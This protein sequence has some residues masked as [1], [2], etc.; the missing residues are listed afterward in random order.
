[1]GGHRRQASSRFPAARRMHAHASCQ[2]SDLPRHSACCASVVGSHVAAAPTTRGSA[3]R[4]RRLRT[5]TDP[6]TDTT[7]PTTTPTTAT[8]HHPHDDDHPPSTTTT[9]TVR[10]RP[11]D[12][13]AR[14]SHHD[15]AG[16]PRRRALGPDAADAIAGH[17]G[18]ETSSIPAL[19]LHVVEVPAAQVDA[20]QSRVPRRRARA[21]AR[22]STRSATPRAAR[23]I[24]P[25]ATSGRFPRSAGKTSTVSSTPRAPR[26]SRCSTPVSTR[27]HP[28]SPGGRSG[29]WSF[30]GSDPATDPNGHGTHVATIAAGG[31][32]DGTGIAGVAYAGVTVMPVRVLG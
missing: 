22:H 4:G 25:T 8:E 7:P 31:A 23:P 13:H 21:S 11:D 16:P 3:A 30:D 6:S 2:S 14:R 28:I 5:T 15:P 26:R 10:S 20:A 19:R 1:M 24:L 27:A 32:D 29:G 12:H 9:T 18:T 17:G